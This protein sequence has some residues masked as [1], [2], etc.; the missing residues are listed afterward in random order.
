MAGQVTLKIE[1]RMMPID[2]KIRTALRRK[3]LDL[4]PK[5]RVLSI[6]AEDYVDWTGD[7]ALR[8]WVVIDEDTTDAELQNGKAIIQL[9]RTIH[10]SLLNKGVTLYPYIFLTKPSEQVAADEEE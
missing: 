10:D 1:R 5:P 3:N 2:T 4:P 8:I 7:E 6:E 9:K